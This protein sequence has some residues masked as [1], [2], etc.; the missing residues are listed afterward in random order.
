MSQTLPVSL[1]GI[2][3]A[4]LITTTN[5]GFAEE[6]QPISIVITGTRTAQTVDQSLAPVSL[7]ERK[8]IEERP[9][10][11]T[12]D[13]LRMTPGLSTSSNG[14]RGASTSVFLRGTESDQSL[15]LIDGVRV[16]SATTGAA[17]LQNIPTDHIERV[18]VVRG[19]RSSLY[20]SEAIGG[21]IQLFTRRP[22][23]DTAQARFSLSGGSHSSV[24]LNA[25][26]SGST[27][28]SWYNASIA[29]FET[30]GFDACRG[31]PFP[32]GG[33]CF[34]NEPDDDGYNNKS[35]LL[36]AGTQFGS[37]IE[38]SINALHIDSELEYDGS[39]QNEQDASNQLL[40]GKL[41]IEASDIWNIDLLAA[42]T[43]DH[44]DNLKDGVFSSRFDTDR[45]QLTFQNDI[46]TG[47]NGT[48]TLGID[49]YQDEVS[50]TTDYTVSSRDNLGLFG[51]YLGRF[52]ATETQV[53]LRNDDN[54]QFGNHT[55]GGVS[56]GQDFA[57]GMRWT[58]AWGSAFKA[59]TFNELYFPGFGNPALDAETSQ[60]IDLGL[61]AQKGIAQ[62]TAN[63]FS[64][65]IDDL[66]TYDVT[67]DRP[68]NI[69][70]A[71]INGVELTASTVIARWNTYANLTFMS[72]E[73]T[74]AGPN[75][76]NTLARRPESL[77]N[78]SMQRSFGKLS[79]LIDIRAQ[80]HSYDDLAN[81]RRLAGFTTLNLNLGY[82]L[83]QDWM[84]NLALN[85]LFDKQYETAEYFNQD[86]LNGMLSLRYTPH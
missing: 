65:T 5:A 72:P 61:S 4:V 42:K 8:Q 15:V 71:R 49:Y 43:R 70:Q 36:S 20:G 46:L 79:T 45:E 56:F 34:T 6:T 29:S 47:K 44:T 48:T 9:A 80:G 82:T 68:V 50:G 63:L 84:V 57:K 73:N 81:T 59:P 37:K 60:S 66:I 32:D 33:G 14:G 16:G 2:L 54:E 51:Q 58:A 27:K 40:S 41:E 21:V 55:T 31:R 11:S 17:A 35:V 52:G 7:I 10:D 69:G 38:A 74:S 23:A 12:T 28:S 76:G 39:F 67:V 77:L 22:A 18:E 75:K 1:T 19:P 78:L 30:E 25:G 53:S 83:T 64:T 13:L 85:N 62:F 86:G 3:T 24:G 26:L